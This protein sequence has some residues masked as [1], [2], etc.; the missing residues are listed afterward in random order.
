MISESALFYTLLGF[1]LT[2]LRKL[3]DPLFEK[4]FEKRVSF[5]GFYQFF[6][7]IVSKTSGVTG[8]E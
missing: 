8:R 4:K 5:T 3:R 1:T 2:V 7:S 6:F